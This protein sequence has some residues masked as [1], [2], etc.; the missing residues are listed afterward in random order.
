MNY[1]GVSADK[2]KELFLQK[3][4][5]TG[6]LMQLLDQAFELDHGIYSRELG[7]KVMWSIFESIVSSADE[8][9]RRYMQ[10]H[11]PEALERRENSYSY[12]SSREMKEQLAAL[13][14]TVEALKTTVADLVPPPAAFDGYDDAV[15]Q[16]EYGPQPAP[17]SSGACSIG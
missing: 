12:V 3:T 5:E 2:Y 11:D 6:E 14:Q 7:P 17:M 8:A 4:K 13:T 10:E 16:A 9:S 1:Y 15:L